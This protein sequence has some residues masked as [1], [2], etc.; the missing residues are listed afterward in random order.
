[1]APEGRA[2]WRGQ[3]K[4]KEHRMASKAHY[5]ALGAKGGGGK[6]GNPPHT[7]QLEVLFKRKEEQ[8]RGRRG[9][10]KNV[11]HVEIFTVFVK[12]KTKKG[13]GVSLRT[14]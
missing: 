10:E 12:Q 11:G 2:K 7:V 8:R 14:R 5:E 9:E 4:T 1:V 6:R 3:A 13:G